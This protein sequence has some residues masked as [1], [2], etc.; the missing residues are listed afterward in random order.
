[1]VFKHMAKL[2]H[3][4]LL[5]FKHTLPCKTVLPGRY[6]FSYFLLI[7]KYLSIYIMHVFFIILR[8]KSKKI[9]RIVGS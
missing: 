6:E 5:Q 9:N 8:D 1:M 2:S 3:F 7:A 4:S